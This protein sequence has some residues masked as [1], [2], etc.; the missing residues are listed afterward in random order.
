MLLR[1]ATIIV[2]SPTNVKRFSFISIGTIFKVE[3]RIDNERKQPRGTK[4]AT[5]TKKLGI[6][7]MKI[8]PS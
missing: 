5:K 3:K 1:N 7:P 6:M 4:S 2:R 8:L